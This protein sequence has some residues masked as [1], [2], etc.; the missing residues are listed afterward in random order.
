LFSLGA[1]PCLALSLLLLQALMLL[2]GP[3]LL[4]LPLLDHRF[5]KGAIRPVA[6][7]ALPRFRTVIARRRR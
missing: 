3:L 5:T 7:C 6:L 2:P 4:D 1:R